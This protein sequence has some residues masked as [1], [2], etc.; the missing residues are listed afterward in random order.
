M[1]G[2]ALLALLERVAIMA[3]MA[4]RALVGLRVVFLGVGSENVWG[5]RR[6]AE[7]NMR[8]RRM[9]QGGR[10]HVI[11]PGAIR[12]AAVEGLWVENE[13]WGGYWCGYRQPLGLLWGGARGE[14]DLR[15]SKGVVW[16]RRWS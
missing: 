10:C 7:V 1:A 14:G 9:G 16:V 5:L 4:G 12:G 8:Y 3:A 11:A 15:A 2:T 6:E 13:D